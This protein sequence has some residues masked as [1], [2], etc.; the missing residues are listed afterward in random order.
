[1]DKNSSEN[2]NCVH[3]LIDDSGT[4][5]CILCGLVLS[6][7]SFDN[8]VTLEKCE[9][10]LFSYNYKEVDFLNEL[11]NRNIISLQVNIDAQKFLNKWC[12]ENI[13]HKKYHQ[14]Y[15]IYLSSVMNNFPLTLKEISY[16]FGQSIKNI[17][18]IEKFV[19]TKIKQSPFDF[20][21]KFCKLLNLTFC[22]QKIIEK[23]L[24]KL[25]DQI[26][27]PPAHVTTEAIIL[28]FPKIDHKLLAAATM[29]P[30]TTIK[31]MA[32]KCA[33]SSKNV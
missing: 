2:I 18:K 10:K 22:D 7:F 11:Y 4:S 20:L 21:E 31:K 3:S 27:A 1:M 26:H 6:M 30:I 28:T 16:H 8:D 32:N 14:A 12:K 23:N 13:P 15:A 25:I 33:R 17:C 5:V 24:L 9:T 19:K 29:L